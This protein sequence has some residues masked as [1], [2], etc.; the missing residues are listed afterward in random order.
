M[1]DITLPASY[2]PFELPFKS[3]TPPTAGIKREII[4]LD[5][6]GEQMGLRQPVLKKKVSP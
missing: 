2:I 6:D 4:E 3:E 1:L 5:S